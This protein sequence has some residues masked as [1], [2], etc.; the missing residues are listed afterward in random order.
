MFNPFK[1]AINDTS[2]ITL[3][4]ILANTLSYNRFS[5]KWGVDVSNTLN[6][7]KALLTYGFESRQLHDW[8]FRDDGILPANSRLKLFKRQEPILCLLPNLLTA[9]TTLLP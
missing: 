3:N 5:T 4:N 1:G 2:L 6:N 8:T 7:N 9:I